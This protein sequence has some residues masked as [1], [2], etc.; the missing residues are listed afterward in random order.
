MGV[1]GGFPFIPLVFYDKIGMRDKHVHVHLSKHFNTIAATNYLSY[2]VDYMH[3][4][5]LRRNSRQMQ[6]LCFVV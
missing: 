6:Q 4:D 3:Y 2:C 5:A 1:D